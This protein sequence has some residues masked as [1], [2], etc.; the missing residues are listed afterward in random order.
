MGLP[1]FQ[2]VAPRKV[3]KAI[4]LQKKSGKFLA[5]GTDLFVAMKERISC[6][7]PL[8][9]LNSISE[10][11]RI[12][13][14]KKK[15]LRVGALT[16]LTQL[17]E[18]LIVQKH[19]PILSQAVPLMSTPQLQNMGTVGG[20]LCLDTRCYYYNQSVFFKKRWEPCFKIGGKTCH[21]VKGGDSC[22]AVYS[23]D[24]APP[25]I[26]LGAK[27]K[28]MGDRSAKEIGLQKFFSGSG[29]KPNILK[30]N[31][32]LSEIVIPV[33]PEHSACSYKKLRL[34][35]TIDFPL[36]GVSVFLRLGERDE[37]CK[38]I[39][40]VLGA[41]GP[42]PFVVEGAAQLMRGK[43]ITPKLI[44]EVSQIAWKAAHPVANT[45]SSPKYRREMVQVLT[46]NA[47]QEALSRIKNANT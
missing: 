16:T 3:A 23:G 42:S 1:K 13:W 14:D 18:N 22:Y 34:R 9:D 38:D 2:Y 19:F 47:I 35:E 15:R 20:N 37:R 12:E 29:I 27:V 11:K 30:F 46:K 33:P 41:V 25:L 28:V 45:A 5:G 17:K 36:L 4:S 44:E 40:V 39:R 7:D 24:M 6:P 8:I 43:E 21:V 31:E 32:L 10:L 26:A